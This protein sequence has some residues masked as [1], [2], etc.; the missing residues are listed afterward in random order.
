MAR[1]ITLVTGQW[2]DVPLEKLAR[3]MSE[4]G[5]D[6]LELGGGHFDILRGAQ[7]RKYCDAILALLDRYHLKVWAISGHVVG[8]QVC[9]PNDSRSDAFAPPEL[10]GKPEEKR[11]WAVATMKDAARAARNLGIEIVTGFVGSS[12]WHLL[13]SWPPVPESMIEAGFRYFAHMWNPIL[14]VFDECGVRFALEVHPT[15]IA[16]DPITTRR[17]LDAVGNRPAFGINLDPSHLQW[18]MVD[19]ARFIHEFR[20][21]IYHVHVKD[22]AVQ[23]TG[24]NSILGS[25]L[26]FGAAER[27]WDFRSP[28]HGDV[29][30]ETLIRALNHIHYQGPLSVEWEDSGMERE[31]GAREALEFVRKLNFSPSSIA[32]DENF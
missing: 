22:V 1:P 13:Y 3:M 20:E 7:D 24:R 10:A 2:G 15:E 5:Y 18:Q 28:G 4:F 26:S 19:P 31:F 11:V 6:G 9:D 8:Q 23:L 25:H 30:F 27:G 17:A 32:F 16:F 14:D 29:D 12:I 21:R